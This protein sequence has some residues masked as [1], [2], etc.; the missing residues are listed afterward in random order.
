[1]VLIGDTGT[2]FGGAFRQF[3]TAPLSVSSL[4]FHYRSQGIQRHGPVAALV[5]ALYESAVP[6]GNW[7]DS[8]QGQSFA[9]VVSMTQA[10]P[11]FLVGLRICSLCWSP[12]AS[13]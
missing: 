5:P 7:Q 10:F 8:F 6:I 1:M 4:A 13:R 9:A 2:W 3:A 11:I 12:P